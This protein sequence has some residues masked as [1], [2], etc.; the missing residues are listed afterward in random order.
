MILKKI[1]KFMDKRKIFF[2]ELI[3]L[4]EKDD[5]IVLI[6]P[7][8][9]FSFTEE[10]ASKFPNR[11][12]NFGVTEQSCMVIASALALD[13]WKPY[14]YSM[15]NFVLFRPAEMVRNAVVHHNAN[16]KI[17]GVKGSEKYKFLGF[18][19]NLAH[20]LEDLEFCRNIGLRANVPMTEEETRKI[21]KESYEEQTPTY[22][23]L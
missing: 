5:K 16:V 1:I 10:F 11:Y 2:E 21:I 4:A 15:I 8:V 23:R 14:V 12:Y 22:V 13:G 3:K 18:S 17:L 7:D 20:Q 6:V 19:H 9:G